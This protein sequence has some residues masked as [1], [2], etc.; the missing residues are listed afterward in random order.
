MALLTAWISLTVVVFAGGS[1]S[2]ASLASIAKPT[3]WP[4]L[5]VLDVL[6]LASARHA[7]ARLRPTRL[8]VVIVGFIGL[9]LL[10]AAWSVAPRL[11]VERAV[12]LAAVVFASVFLDAGARGRPERVRGIV[13]GIAA[14]AGVVAMLGFIVLA[15]APSTGAQQ[16]NVITPWRFR[17]FG[18]NPNTISML[19][20]VV[21]PLA[22]WLA[23]SSR[24]RVRMAWVGV[25]VLFAATVILSGSRGA[26]LAEFGG[27]L[28]LTLA[29]RGRSR[30]LVYAVICFVAFV[31]AVGIGQIYQ[32]TSVAASTAAPT[33]VTPPPAKRAVDPAGPQPITIGRLED[34]IGRGAS[35]RRKLFASSGRLD[36]WEWALGQA[37][38]RPLLG[39]GFGTEDLV[40]VDRLYAFE[41]RRPENSFVGIALQLGVAGVALLAAVALAVGLA[42]RQS[43]P[44]FLSN[45]PG[46]GLLTACSGAAL[47]GLVMTVSQ[48]Y[49][50]AAGNVATLTVWTCAL[51]AAG[52]AGGIRDHAI[53]R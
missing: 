46:R 35:T 14:G 26:L 51:L 23:W 31:L 36:A 30:R 5:F 25:V 42:V 53:G 11:T 43:L 10:S 24:R 37:R 4:V 13:V 48:S 2:V 19:V 38:K 39:Y 45:E 52:S 16:T 17:G 49:V 22:L 34:E 29:A 18:E 9:M 28:V 20:A 15:I 50:Y 8:H 21:T 12:S 33:A 7:G 41:G 27:T 1:S 6:A 47:A 40:F 44:T 32:P 3:R